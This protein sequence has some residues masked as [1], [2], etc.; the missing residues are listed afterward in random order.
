MKSLFI[1]VLL[2]LGVFV[3][4]YAHSFSCSTFSVVNVYPDS[5]NSSNYQITLQC[6]ASANQ[7][8]SYPFVPY[9]LDC[10]D[11]TVATGGLFYFGHIGQ[12]TQD[13][14]VTLTGNGSI[15]CYPLTVYF[16]ISY[17]TITSDTC[18]LSYGTVGLQNYFNEENRFT[19]YPNPTGDQLNITGAAELAGSSY[20]IF[21]FS[22]KTVS[23]GVLM[24][25]NQ[26][27]NLKAISSGSYIFTIAGKVNLRFNVFRE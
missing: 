23:S 24:K 17:D 21:D 15:N 22:G 10:N 5:L 8:F 3:E 4:S 12:T 7:F 25:E 6:N 9:V 18:Q 19:I 27:V 16:I 11:D 2:F 20:V 14:P 1:A 13:Y 26:S